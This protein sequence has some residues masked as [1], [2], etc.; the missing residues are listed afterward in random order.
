MPIDMSNARQTEADFFKLL[1][2][3][4]Q[5]SRLDKSK[6]SSQYKLVASRYS[7]KGKRVAAG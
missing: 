5:A 2:Q 7:L 3:N 6:D 1:G 4:L